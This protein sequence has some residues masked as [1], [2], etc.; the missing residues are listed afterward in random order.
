MIR[1]HT[2]AALITF[3]CIP[4]LAGGRPVAIQKIENNAY[5][6]P[7]G[8]TY[9]FASLSAEDRV[10]VRWPNAPPYESRE[11]GVKFKPVSDAPEPAEAKGGRDRQFGAIARRFTCDAYTGLNGRNIRHLQLLPRPIPEYSDEES[12]IVTGA[13]FAFATG[14]NPDAL[15]LLE[16]NSTDEEK[17][18]WRYA[19]VQMT[20]S[21]VELKYDGVELWT[22]KP[23]PRPRHFPT[24][25]YMWLRK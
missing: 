1:L 13:I 23:E 19:G 24:W 11:P 15:L 5:S 9:C 7:V 10:R 2:T 3:L 17:P 4:C 8:W 20:N 16:V 14:T 25:T 22:A 21:G 18:S 12:G 6:K